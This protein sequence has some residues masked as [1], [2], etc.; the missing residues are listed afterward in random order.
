MARSL[1][2]DLYRG[3]FSG[4]ETA[5]FLRGCREKGI[6]TAFVGD[7]RERPA[8][9]GEAHVALSFVGE[10]DLESDPAGLLLQQARTRSLADLWELSRSH[11]GRVRQAENFILVPNLLCVA[12]A[13]LFGFTGMTAVM[14]SNLGTL[15]LYRRASD[16]LRELDAP[17][18]RRPGP[19]HRAG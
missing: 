17:G 7:C 18:P 9:A 3:D 1:G 10:A 15:G 8:A 14:L 4:E 16:S 6:R 2:V 12:G 13:F 19:R 5:A 11:A